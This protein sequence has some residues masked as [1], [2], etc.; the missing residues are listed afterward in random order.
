MS[1]LNR[2]AHSTLTSIVSGSS[3]PHTQR[4]ASGS[5]GRSCRRSAS[6]LRTETNGL[7]RLKRVFQP[8]WI[9]SRGELLVLHLECTTLVVRANQRRPNSKRTRQLSLQAYTGTASVLCG[10][11]ESDLRARCVCLIMATMSQIW[12]RCRVRCMAHLRHQQVT[13]SDST[14]PLETSAFAQGVGQQPNAQV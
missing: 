14:R 10:R 12:S 8:L 1:S 4:P 11:R 5:W 6:S 9:R 2:Q 3:W 7:R 13:A